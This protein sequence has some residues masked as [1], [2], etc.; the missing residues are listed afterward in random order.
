MASITQKFGF[1]IGSNC[2][3]ILIVGGILTGNSDGAIVGA[4]FTPE[5]VR[6]LGCS[7]VEDS[8]YSVRGATSNRPAG[9]VAGQMFYDTTLGLP[10]WWNS[11][12]SAWQRADGTNV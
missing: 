4:G 5:K 8:A 9:T 10:L 2:S 7:G 3:G 12:A 11:T 1:N 6:V